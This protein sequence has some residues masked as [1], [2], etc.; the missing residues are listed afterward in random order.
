LDFDICHSILE[1]CT[2]DKGSQ[3]VLD[4]LWHRFRISVSLNPSKVFSLCLTPTLHK[5]VS[6][7]IADMLEMVAFSGQMLDA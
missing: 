4:L 6:T 2:I 7:G 1:S 5:N 3:C